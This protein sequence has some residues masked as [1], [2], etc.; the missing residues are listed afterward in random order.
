MELVVI[1]IY[2]GISLVSA[3]S[4]ILTSHI[5]LVYAT[6]SLRLFWKHFAR[7]RDFRKDLH[8]KTDK[9]IGNRAWYLRRSVSLS[10]IDQGVYDVMFRYMTWRHMTSLQ[11]TSVLSDIQIL[12]WI[13][14]WLKS[15]KLIV[16]IRLKSNNLYGTDSRERVTTYYNRGAFKVPES[17]PCV[18]DT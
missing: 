15:S 5:L 9:E 4:H 6:K 12:S 17:G 7:W 2:L 3:T 13:H 16:F 1:I 11:M 14:A 10:F 18:N 8:M